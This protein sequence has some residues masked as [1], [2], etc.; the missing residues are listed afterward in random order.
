MNFG[1]LVE[2]SGVNFKGQAKTWCD[3]IVCK[4]AMVLA[5]YDSIFNCS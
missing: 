2:V 5:T 1:R 4:S 3:V